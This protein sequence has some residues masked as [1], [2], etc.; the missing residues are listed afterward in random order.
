MSWCENPRTHVL[1]AIN[2]Q[3]HHHT[4]IMSGFLAVS[5]FPLSH[6]FQPYTPFRLFFRMCIIGL[7]AETRR[8]SRQ[9]AGTLKTWVHKISVAL[10]Y[11]IAFERTR[12]Y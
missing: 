7:V 11:V 4:G 8:L 1:P 12:L 10:A 9:L 3:K 2:E 6:T 5:F